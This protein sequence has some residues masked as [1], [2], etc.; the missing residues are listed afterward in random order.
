MTRKCEHGVW[1][2]ESCDKCEREVYMTNADDVSNLLR[3]IRDQ[4]EFIKPFIH[5]IH[6]IMARDN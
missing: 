6:T 3:D 2:D 4:L 5:D 1:M